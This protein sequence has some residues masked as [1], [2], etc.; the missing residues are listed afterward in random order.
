[1]IKA[2]IYKDFKQLKSSILIM[3]LILVILSIFIY[4]P[5]FC[6]SVGAVFA[7]ALVISTF[8]FDEKSG[9][10]KEAVACVKNRR[11]I[12]NEKYLLMLIFALGS[13]VTTLLIEF[14]VGRKQEFMS[15]PFLFFMALLSFSL[16][17]FMSG[18][19]IPFTIGLGADKGRLISMLCYILPTTIFV[20]TAKII[21][22]KEASFAIFIITMVIPS[23]AVAAI[24][25][26]VSTI[27][28]EKKDF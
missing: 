15:L 9:F 1:M 23:V 22:E 17:L 2:F 11:T 25:Y 26:F 12:V 14:F 7:S 16:S 27:L 8:S 28:L 20:M 10:D 21:S 18:L 13:T 6:L 24:S 3:V 5:G 4:Q 19:S